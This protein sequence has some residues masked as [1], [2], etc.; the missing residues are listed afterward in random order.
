MNGGTETGLQFNGRFQLVSVVRRFERLNG[1]LTFV[2]GATFEGGEIESFAFEACKTMKLSGRKHIHNARKALAMYSGSIM[3]HGFYVDMCWLMAAGY[4]RFKRGLEVTKTFPQSG[5]RWSGVLV[6]DVQPAPRS[7]SGTSRVEVHFRVITGPLCSLKFAQLLSKDYVTKIMAKSMGTNKYYRAK[8]TEIVGMVCVVLLQFEEYRQA[9][10][11]LHV[12]P[13]ALTFNKKLY[14]TRSKPCEPWGYTWTC[15]E[16]PIGYD[17]DRG[18]RCARATHPQTYV[19]RECPRCKK[20]AWFDPVSRSPI[21]IECQVSKFKQGQE[22][23]DADTS[24][25]G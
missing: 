1:V 18:T 3:N 19:H 15:H 12:P 9:M 5:Q 16:C 6:T 13:A 20:E 4:K 8:T 22:R 11:D 7:K 21:C 23:L 25:G 2:D 10:I 24:S 17:T 14:A